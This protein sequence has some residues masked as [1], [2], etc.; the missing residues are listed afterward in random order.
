MRDTEREEVIRTATEALAGAVMNGSRDAGVYLARLLLLDEDKSLFWY[1]QHLAKVLQETGEGKVLSAGPLYRSM[2]Q[3]AHT[4]DEAAQRIIENGEPLAPVA[5]LHSQGLE[6]GGDPI[7][8]K[9]EAG[10][11]D[12]DERLRNMF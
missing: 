10:D 12:A 11:T 1:V 3:A 9:D 7:Y 2:V 4:I 8:Q 6:W 5:N